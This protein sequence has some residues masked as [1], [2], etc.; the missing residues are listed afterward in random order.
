MAPLTTTS[1]TWVGGSRAGLDAHRLPTGLRS[2]RTAVSTAAAM[3]SLFVILTD[4]RPCINAATGINFGRVCW[5]P[6]WV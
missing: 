5:R 3:R 6:C 1:S 2:D 4:E